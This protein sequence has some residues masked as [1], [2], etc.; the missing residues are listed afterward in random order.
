MLVEKIF[1]PNEM[2]QFDS[3]TNSWFLSWPWTATLCNNT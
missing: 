1:F 3:T 2:L